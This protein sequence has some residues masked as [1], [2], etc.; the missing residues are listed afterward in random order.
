MRRRTHGQSMV[1]MALLL[2]VLLVVTF[3]IIDFGWYIYGYATVYMAA[4][5][6]AEEAT[7]LP[8]LEYRVGVGKT[9]DMSDNCVSSIVNR[10]I[11]SGPLFGDLGNVQ[12]IEI[13]YPPSAAKARSLGSPV[14]VKLTY[15]ITPLTPLWQLVPVFS[16]GG[17]LPVTITTRRTIEVLGANPNQ[18]YAPNLT[19]CN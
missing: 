7:M 9:P 2:P 4:R 11:K 14:Q 16:N 17:R 6:A 10:V 3:A 1:E 19:A 12:N 5:N 8:P 15:T 18:R 13:S